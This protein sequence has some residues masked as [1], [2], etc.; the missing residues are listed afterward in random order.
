MRVTSP[1]VLPV[2]SRERGFRVRDCPY[3]TLVGPTDTKHS[4][5]I[6]ERPYR[7]IILDDAGRV[8]STGLPKFAN[9]GEPGFE[10]QHEDLRAAVARGTDLW[11]TDKADGTLVIRSV[12]DGAVVWRTRGS[13]HLGAFE[14]SVMAQVARYPTL[15]DPAFSPAGSL[16]FEF[17]SADPA[18]RVVIGH[19]ADGL[20]L[21]GATDHA[22][23]SIAYKPEL[24]QLAA[25]SGVPLIDS[26]VLVGS[27]KDWRREIK[28][29]TGREGVV[30]R[31]PNGAMTKLKADAYLTLHRLKTQFSLRATKRMILHED[32]DSREA[33]ERH[34]TKLGADWEIVQST[35]PLIEAAMD[36][37]AAA[38][39]T[40]PQLEDRVDLLC[41]ATP[42][43]KTAQK[44][45][46]NAWPQAERQA[47]LLLLD[48]RYGEAGLALRNI[49]LVEALE[50]F[51]DD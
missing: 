9:L 31:L 3:G 37:R 44:E 25:S 41:I 26:V 47:G 22:T 40:L 13:H 15:S 49:L 43:N 38:K 42:G 5:R 20:T 17:T 36:A 29:W 7:S 27:L 21:I 18:L 1:I 45:I 28:S 32:L 2:P 33:F 48:G 8:V 30:V 51:E 35:R 23:L 11:V 34:L 14:A 50:P 10:D 46:I 4:W 6:D 12:I 24:E 19:A 16:Q 39:A